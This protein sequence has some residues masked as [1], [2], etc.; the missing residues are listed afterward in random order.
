[1]QQQSVRR[2]PP[3][4]RIVS[5]GVGGRRIVLHSWSTSNTPRL[6]NL[7]CLNAD[8][9][10]CWR[11]ALPA[12]SDYD[13]FVEVRLDGPHVVAK[14]YRGTTVRLDCSTGEPLTGTT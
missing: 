3:I 6:H 5:T 9:D 12:G 11:A 14:T 8:D 13:C 10:I 1:M 2:P 4:L 7:V